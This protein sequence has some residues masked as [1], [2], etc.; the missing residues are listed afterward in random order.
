MSISH[1]FYLTKYAMKQL[2]L[3]LTSLL[4][5]ATAC[6]K[7]EAP[8]LIISQTELSAPSNGN[9]TTITLTANNPWSVSGMDW[10]T[11]SPSRGEGAGEV[12]ITITVK[13]N[14]TYDAR[15][16]TLTFSS[17]D[18]SETLSVNQGSNFGIVLPQ[19]TYEISSD[20]QQISVEVK[21][22]VEYEVDINV[23]WIKLNGTKALSSKTYIF[24]I[25]KNNTYDAREGAISIK[26]KNNDKSEIIK[27]KQVQ[28]DAILISSKEYN[29]SSE[30]QS[31][32]IKL[33]TNVDLEVVIPDNSKDWITHTATKALSDKTL[34]LDIEANDG[35]DSRSSEIIIK[36]K[37]STLADTLKISQAQK[38]AIIIS[39]KEYELTSESHA[40]EIKLQTNVDLDIIIPETAQNWVLYI[41]TRTLI[42]KTVI[43]NVKANDTYEKRECDVYIVNR[44]SSIQDTLK[45]KQAQNDAIILPSNEYNLT[46][47]AQ[48][49]EIKLKTNIDFDIDIS[50]NTEKWLN[51]LSTKTLQDKTLLFSIN[52]NNTVENRSCEVVLRSGK[53]SKV[54]KIEQLSINETIDYIDEYGINHGK[55]I[56]I[57]NTIWSPVNCGYKASTAA[58]KGYPYGKLYQWGRKYGQ[59]YN[60][61]YDATAPYDTFNTNNDDAIP[62]PVSLEIGQNPDNHLKIYIDAED[63][64]DNNTSQSN[65][66]ILWNRGTIDNPIK[67]EYDPC[68]TGWRLPTDKELI[69]LVKNLIPDGYVYMTDQW[70]KSYGND[71]DKHYKLPGILLRSPNIANEGVFLPAAGSNLRSGVPMGRGNWG[72]Y[73][74][75]S[76]DHDAFSR[77]IYFSFNEE[78]DTGIIREGKYFRSDSYSVRCV[79]E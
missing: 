42:D 16:C 68:P 25:E 32:E 44:A 62:G 18:L 10:C 30:A 74:S 75:S 12:P 27:V 67:T 5:L 71:K 64:V 35:Y 13:E 76:S 65:K 7:E 14:T 47:K 40:L 58:D 15:N 36:K 23:D 59:G 73:W 61:D 77:Y 3:F 49:L 1:A 29:L 9:S 48:I 8:V 21:A 38:D 39:Q 57:G 6:S 69:Q 66:D 60:K 11:V 26:E 53:I 22:N 33:Q 46:C 34:V 70:V 19:N 41:E 50:K 72:G 45:L 24:D 51:Y 52:E 4:I 28:L 37:N 20:T 78:Q 43:L 56:V 55:G 79:L 17:L 2:V 54:I 63:W 31:L